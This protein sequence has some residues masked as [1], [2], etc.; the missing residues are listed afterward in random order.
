MRLQ[1]WGAQW[2]LESESVEKAALEVAEELWMADECRDDYE[3]WDCNLLVLKENGELEL[4]NVRRTNG[5]YTVEEVWLVDRPRFPQ[6]QKEVG[7][8]PVHT[9]K[10]AVSPGQDRLRAG[11]PG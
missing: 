7:S 11:K 2:N 8:E 9:Q 10:N 4:V 6:K 3:P 1:V 5:V